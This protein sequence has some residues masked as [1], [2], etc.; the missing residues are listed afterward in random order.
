MYLTGIRIR[1][2]KSVRDLTLVLRPGLNVLVGPNEAGKSTLME[3]LHAAFFVN[4][5]STSRDTH[6]FRT[7]ESQGDPSVRILFNAG[8]KDYELEKHFLGPKKGKLSCLA[9]GLET[10]NK[11]RIA[12][13]LAGLIPLWTSDGTSLQHTF[14]I[15]QRSLEDTILHLAKD[16][17]LRAFLQMIVFQADGDVPAIRASL[18][19]KI[20][21]LGKGWKHP[22]KILGPV[23]SAE[24]DMEKLTA[25]CKELRVVLQAVERDYARQRDLTLK[26]GRLERQIREDEGV[27]SA[28]EKYRQAREALQRANAA[29]DAHGAALEEWKNNEEKMRELE[30]SFQDATARQEECT[31]VIAALESET[32]RREA[33]LKLL[34]ESSLLA[35]VEELERQIAALRSRR[36]GEA[37]SA[38]ALTRARHL[39]KDMEVTQGKLSAAQLK[40]E[41]RAL[42]D[43]TLTAAPDHSRGVENALS[44]G[45][46]KIFR[47]DEHLKLGVGGLVELGIS[48]GVTDA[49][50]LHGALTHAKESLEGIFLTY[51][52]KSLEELADRYE[53]EQ[54]LAREI[55]R[56]E[57]E[58][59]VRLNGRTPREIEGAVDVLK[60]MLETLRPAH[61]GLPEAETLPSFKSKKDQLVGELAHLAAEMKQ[62]QGAAEQFLA[63]HTSPEAALSRKK[64]LAR[65]M[66]KTEAALEA[67][68][69]MELGDEKLFLYT[70]RLEANRKEFSALRDELLGINGALQ[71][72]TVSSDQV[73][74]REAECAG[75]REIFESCRRDYEAYRIVSDTLQEAERSVS[76]HFMQPVERKVKEMLPVLTAGR[77][78]GLALDETLKVTKIR[79]GVLDV[80]PGA[81]STGAKG[82]LALALRLALV[83]SI[84]AGERQS[85]IIDDALVNFDPDRLQ[86]AKKLLSEF[87]RRHQIL[88]LTCHPEMRDWHDALIQELAP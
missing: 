61:S 82:Q 58:K 30:S 79:Y 9:T 57:S 29:F 18:E 2:F 68:P 19:R 77:Y 41:A 45:E 23:A 22:A 74:L 69:R 39:A 87:S 81:L 49:P 78:T 11:E 27:M 76:Q 6:E 50:T 20:A 60:K 71:R 13:E 36:Q 44:T 53:K 55:S 3:A 51:G 38:E 75:A 72:A 4:A 32:L 8:G 52:V 59:S 43:V 56:M 46:A 67:I 70:Q 48:S 28:A 54:A 31:E 17:N 83:D 84:A 15:E 35:G 7:W 1:H 88:Y 12:S 40:V 63:T 24:R 47:A 64:D 80:P 25:E 5:D 26:V 16:E 21:E 66:A 85:V 73:R 65:E 33:D 10:W 14:W 86:E 62:R 34:G 42:K 37:V